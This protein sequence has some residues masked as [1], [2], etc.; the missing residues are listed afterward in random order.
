LPRHT[1]PI[2]L[3]ISQ[4]FR[5]EKVRIISSLPSCSIFA[6]T[7]RC[8]QPLAHFRRLKRARLLG[9]VQA[10]TARCAALAR[11]SCVLRRRG[12]RQ[13]RQQ[14]YLRRASWRTNG[15]A[16]RRR[17]RTSRACGHAVWSNRPAG[18]GRDAATSESATWSDAYAT[19]VSWPEQR[20]RRCR[21]RTLDGGL[22]VSVASVPCRRAPGHQPQQAP[23]LSP[24]GR[25]EF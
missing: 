17:R 3:L 1:A 25:R 18:P 16:D 2:I 9:C 13:R 14:R 4:I 24:L 20:A 6:V 23:L 21:T 8:L 22:L 12:L 19:L 10:A 5:R 7:H 15:A 11:L